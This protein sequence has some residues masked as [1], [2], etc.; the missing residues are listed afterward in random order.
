[1]VDILERGLAEL[2]ARFSAG[3]DEI[4]AKA[5][6]AP[7]SLDLLRR[8]VAEIEFF[9]QAYGLVGAKDRDELIAKHILDSLAPLSAVRRL[10]PPGIPIVA[11]ARLRRG[12]SRHPSRDLPAG[13][14]FRASRTH[15]APGRIP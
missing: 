6:S 5:V 14:Q 15:G 4:S 8:Y 10:L 1:M 2:A 7:R 11:D 3:A 9:N 13:R 12:P